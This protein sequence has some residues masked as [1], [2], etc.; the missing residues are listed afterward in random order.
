MKL[1]DIAM[2]IDHPDTEVLVLDS[3]TYR[4]CFSGTAAE[5]LDYSGLNT[6]RVTGINVVD[7]VL[8]IRAKS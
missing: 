2:A 5:L 1:Y 4:V 6:R 7:G 8:K 3:V